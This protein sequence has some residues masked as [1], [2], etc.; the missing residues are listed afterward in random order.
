MLMRAFLEAAGVASI[1]PFVAVVSSP[2]LIETNRY[3]AAA[4]DAVGAAGGREFLVILG[5][6]VLLLF[7]ASL[8]L[9]ALTSYAIFRFSN[10]R[11]HSIGCRLL[12]AYLRQPYEFFLSRNTADLAKTILT[13]VRTVT[14]GI[15]MRG[16]RALSGVIA[17]TALLGLLLAVEPLLSLAVF[18]VLGGAY[19][20]I[21][22]ASR[23]HLRHIGRDRVRANRLRFILAGEALGGIKELRLLGGERAYLER[24]AQP[25][26]DYARHHATSQAIGDLPF[27]LVQ[28]VAFGGVLALVVFLLAREGSIQAA[29]PIIALYAL[30]GYRLLPTFQD[31]FA[32]ATEFAF[33]LPALDALHA[34]LVHKERGASAAQSVPAEPLPLMS[35][36]RFDSVSYRF[37]AA[38]SDTV[39][40]LSFAVPAGSSVAFVGGT[41]AGKS[42]TVDLLLGLLE[43]TAGSIVVDGVPLTQERLRAWQRNIGYVPQAV[44]LADDTVAAN[45]AFGV[46]SEQIDFVAV[47]TAAR[48]AHI[49]DFI[50]GELPDGYDT[51]IGERGV[52]ISGGQR[53]RLAIARALYRD[54]DV[55]VLDEATSALDNAT[56]AAVMES[57]EALLGR[58]TVIVVAHRLSTTRKC[59]RLFLLSHGRLVGAG[60]LE[61]LS[62]DNPAFRKLIQAGDATASA[63]PV[64]RRAGAP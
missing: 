10:M 55:I 30:A 21:Y 11:M 35:E 16:L 44:F 49:H 15:V 47:T 13:E 28:A 26:R 45:I 27:Y 48:L 46:P 56:E 57:I 39:K 36:I 64:R 23:K 29:L 61:E 6:L 43:P 31:V 17:M 53:Q 60:T 5:L 22:A 62:R 33:A 50:V 12:S 20:A 4:K 42:T 59:D 63:P 7:V 2:E 1:M 38:D 58:K 3:L 19:A 40:E 32:S 25:S 34:D 54:P 41:G 8:A 52:R 18:T 9:K 24:F 51:V 14:D 37:P